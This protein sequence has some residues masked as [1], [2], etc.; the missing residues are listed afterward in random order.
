M[1]CRLVVLSDKALAGDL[2][3]D[4]SS[5]SKIMLGFG[6]DTKEIIIKGQN[7]K[8]DDFSSPTF[9]FL[10][11]EFVD[12]FVS[13]RDLFY[14]SKSEIVEGEGVLSG[15]EYPILVL[16]LE[17][18]L[19]KLVRKS[20]EIIKSR[21]SL[22]NV[23]TFRLFS[24]P[25]SVVKEKIATLNL[26]GE[27]KLAGE[28]LLTD[29]YLIQSEKT[30]FISDDEVIINKKFGE[31]LYAQSNM[32]LPE[33]AAKMI[34]LS[35][36][37]IDILDSFTYGQVATQLLK[38]GSSRLSS[39]NFSYSIENGFIKTDEEQS[40]RDE[41]EMINK[42]S[43]LSIE[44]KKVHIAIVVAGRKVGTYYQINLAIGSKKSIE[45]FNL[46]IEGTLED[47]IS[48][49]TD[50]ALFNLIKK[51]RKKDFENL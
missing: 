6:V 34:N 11:D 32:S 17:G 18:D 39:R 26:S 48:I 23:L 36:I 45:V 2:K 7:E 9:L 25:V 40:Y 20:M 37:K 50:S 21:Y 16:P 24:L 31:N 22:K 49:A 5:I 47:A 30:D 27:Y 51:L 8:F 1:D 44:K 33:V 13:S 35:N 38:C 15:D 28:G 4:F 12:D 3:I 42:L 10:H 29:I 14:K 19:N 41:N 43:F 46:S